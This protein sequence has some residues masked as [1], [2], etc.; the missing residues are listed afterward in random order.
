MSNQG[1]ELAK[2]V[3]SILAFGGTAVAVVIGGK[4]SRRT[5]Q[6]KRAER[7]LGSG[8]WIREFVVGCRGW[9]GHYGWITR[10]RCGM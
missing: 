6:W 10:G 8:L 1:V 7:R 3:V 9:R 4:T 2:L 5:E